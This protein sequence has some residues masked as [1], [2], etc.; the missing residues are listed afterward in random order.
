M[1]VKIPCEPLELL[2]PLDFREQRA[3]TS[4]LKGQTFVIFWRVFEDIRGF[5]VLIVAVGLDFLGATVSDEDVF[6]LLRC[7]LRLIE[8]GLH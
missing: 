4:R 8:G 2:Y 5:W 3:L 1:S 7:Y 6:D